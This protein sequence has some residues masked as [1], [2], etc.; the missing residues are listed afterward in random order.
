MDIVNKL[1]NKINLKINELVTDPKAEA[2]AA[3]E[4]RKK[5]IETK[6]IEEKEKKEAA[7]KE[8]KAK[9][10]EEARSEWDIIKSIAIKTIV[11][12]V[13]IFI[14][15]LFGSLISNIAIHRHIAIRLLY[16]IYGA[17]GGVAL[18]FASL[19][20]PPL[21][22]LGLIINFILYKTDKLPHW[23]A[24]MPLTTAPPS[25]SFL[26]RL[27]KAPFYWNPES[28]E[29]KSAYLES[30]NKYK[31]FLESQLMST[32]KNNANKN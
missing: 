25:D 17:I 28:P 19:T 26:S 13:G 11:S 7:I 20:F 27:F 1:T 31:K 8:E 18:I 22:I 12:I 3:E 30:M 21:I 29:H 24:F 16:F 9:E 10:A 23:Y 6:Q 2:I 14:I 32:D 15:L 5:A 4:E